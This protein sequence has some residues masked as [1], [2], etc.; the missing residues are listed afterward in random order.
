MFR[1]LPP[2]M[3]SPDNPIT[4]AKARLG[5]KLFED[6]GL[7]L[8]GD[9]SCATCHPLSKY[10]VDGLPTSKGHA[11]KLGDRNAPTVFNAALQI[12][13]FWDGRAATVEEQAKGPLLN[14]SEMAM[15][16][17][18]AVVA[19]VKKDAAYREA[20]RLAFP[21]G[22]GEVVTIENITK[23]IGAFE[24][25]LVTPARWDRFVA[26]E[27]EALG[28]DEQVGLSKF[29]SVGCATC[30]RGTLVGGDRYRKL[31]S[32]VPWPKTTDLGRH[33]VTGAPSDEMVF[34][35]ASL[36]NVERTAPYF[37]DGSVATLDEA[38]RA[39]GRHQLDVELGEDDVRSIVVFLR[40][41]T[42]II[43][44]ELL[45]PVASDRP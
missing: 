34:K 3:A 23:A 4:D 39:M 41:L 44:P 10:G 27:H 16:N 20:F 1:P 30:H 6:A 21:G 42:G 31:G 45:T 24:R 33:R 7:S 9:V 14:P 28:V 37:H 17:A 38:V 11:G 15:E 22:E 36:R 25:T 8:A 19:T 18:E 5:R 12:A 43:A 26:G 32:R 35:V 2:W 13:M 40:S 29:V